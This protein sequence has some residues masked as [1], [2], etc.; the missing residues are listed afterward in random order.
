MFACG[1]TYPSVAQSL[2]V[3]RCEILT[4]GTTSGQMLN[5]RSFSACQRWEVPVAAKY[6]PNRSIHG[7]HDGPFIKGF[8]EAPTPP[9][10][11]T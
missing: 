10:S 7:G 5:T 11:R 6:H 4:M 1:R 9:V 2:F 8:P 3:F